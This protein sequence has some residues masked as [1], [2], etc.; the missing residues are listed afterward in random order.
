MNHIVNIGMRLE[1][2]VQGCFIGDVELDKLGLLAADQFNAMKSLLKGVVQ[3]IDDDHLVASLKKSKNR[4][5][6]DVTRSSERCK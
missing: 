5:G 1:H 4:E 2:F 3:I 6:T